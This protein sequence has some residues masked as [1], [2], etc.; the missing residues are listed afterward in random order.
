MG[1]GTTLGRYVAPRG[2][3]NLPRWDGRTRGR[4]E[5]WYLTLNAPAEHAAF[6]LRY[7]LYAPDQEEAFSELWGHFFDAR[8]P[9]KSF[10]LRE[11]FPRDAFSLGG[12]GLIRMGRAWLREGRALGGLSGQGHALEWDLHFTPSTTA[13]FSAPFFLRRAVEARRSNWCVPNPDLEYQ[14]HVVVDGRRFEL[15]AAPGQQAHTFGRQHPR[16]WAWGCCNTFDGGAPVVF[17]G[18]AP[19]LSVGGWTPTP[20][21]VYVRYDGVDYACNSLVTVG[22][23][24]HSEIAF[25][26]WRFS[27]KGGDLAFRGRLWG[28]PGRFLQVEYHDPDGTPLYCC[29]SEVASL[30]LEVSRRGHH[31]DTLRASGTAGL[32]FT[33]RQRRAEI[34]LCPGP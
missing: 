22:L 17:Q 34:P 14:G 31:I 24:A 32:E 4:Y 9:E 12:D 27:C 11:R 20:T 30:E 16:A 13:F 1:L 5:V 25:P 3:E 28:E 15:A 19:T 8:Q 2:T 23:T 26:Q 29:N 33:S 6:W 7:T 18:I 10:G 21:L